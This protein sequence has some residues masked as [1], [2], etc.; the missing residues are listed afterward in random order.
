MKFYAWMVRNQDTISGFLAGV[1]VMAAGE[2]FLLGN[3]GNGVLYLLISV[4][5]LVMTGQ[6]LKPKS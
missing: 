6:Q 2:Q 4:I 1:C 3:T 5:N